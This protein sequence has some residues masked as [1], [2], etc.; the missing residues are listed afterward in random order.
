M[1]L[2]RKVLQEDNILCEVDADTHYYSDNESMD[3]DIDIARTSSRKQLRSST[4]PNTP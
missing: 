1:A 2:R 4:G 3:G